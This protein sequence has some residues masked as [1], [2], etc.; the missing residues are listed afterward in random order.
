VTI[1]PVF[2]VDEQARLEGEQVLFDA[3][4]LSALDRAANTLSAALGAG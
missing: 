1:A 3:A 2:L 4:A